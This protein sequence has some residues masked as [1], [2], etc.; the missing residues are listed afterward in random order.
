MASCCR[1][2]QHEILL[3]REALA[4]RRGGDKD[5][6]QIK[7]ALA[8]AVRLM[9]EPLKNAPVV[10][11]APVTPMTEKTQTPSK[12]P[13]PVATPVEDAAMAETPN[14][15]PEKVWTLVGARAP[16]KEEPAAVLAADP[17]V[18]KR[19]KRRARKSG[20]GTKALIGDPQEATP[21]VPAKRLPSQRTPVE[22]AASVAPLS[23]YNVELGR[24]AAARFKAKGGSSRPSAAPRAIRRV[25]VAG[26]PLPLGS[27]RAMLRE[28]GI[29]TQFV[30][31]I[32]FMG[33]SLAELWIYETEANAIT[34]RLQEGG[35]AIERVNPR[36]PN[37]FRGAE[38]AHLSPREKVDRAE[39]AFR[40]RLSALLDRC[41]NRDV[42]QHAESLIKA[43]PPLAELFRPETRRP[44]QTTLV[45]VRRPG[46]TALVGPRRPG[47]SRT[48]APPST[49]RADTDMDGTPTSVSEGTQS[50]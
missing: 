44:G 7:K 21:V 35:L 46:Q 36:S 41:Q 20:T 42:R 27:W 28:L 1:L 6:S 37:S 17:V 14:P 4:K 23:A 49:T 9:A 38:S 50:K 43:L 24:A 19:R 29:N 18:P 8:A 47:P 3:L 31:E 12:E 16:G 39:A 22:T 2:A 13:T 48:V 10:P 33:H 40:Q 15:L 30:P 32:Q 11:P 45:G 25:Y 34:A 26:R 5:L